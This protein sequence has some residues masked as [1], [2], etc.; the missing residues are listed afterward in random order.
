MKFF[1]ASVAVSSVVAANVP[2]DCGVSDTI[3]DTSTVLT[4][5]G[6]CVTQ[7][8]C[9][10]SM[11]ATG[12]KP[13]PLATTQ[14]ECKLTCQPKTCGAINS[15][16]DNFACGSGLTLDGSQT[17]NE[18]VTSDVCCKD[19]TATCLYTVPSQTYELFEC[20]A[21]LTF[22]ASQM[23]NETVT[24]AVCCKDFTPTCY[25]HSGSILAQEEYP[26]PTGKTFNSSSGAMNTT[27]TTA[28]NDAVCCM[29]YTAT[30]AFT[31]DAGDRFKCP[32]GKIEKGAVGNPT[33][34]T[35]CED[36][37]TCQYVRQKL[38]SDTTCGTGQVLIAA[39]LTKPYESSKCCEFSEDAFS[40]AIAAS[41]SASAIAGLLFL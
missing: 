35:C 40:G 15:D 13:A 7:I 31:N 4:T 2:F 12:Q 1:L 30:C 19:F 37:T 32:A 26:C 21:G 24:K 38:C 29:T 39:M 20:G 22:D 16:N 28:E 11:C 36:P 18:T 6:C 3:N 10:E 14:D 25:F 33:A 41:M 27:G 34:A 5:A 8:A 17:Y 9:T 23:N